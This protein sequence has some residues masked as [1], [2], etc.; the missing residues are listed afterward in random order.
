MALLAFL[1]AQAGLKTFAW[2]DVATKPHLSFGEKVSFK[3]APLLYHVEQRSYPL[4]RE[5]TLTPRTGGPGFKM[6]QLPYRR[7]E[8][9]VW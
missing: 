2:E 8:R 9:W 7:W 5:V 3:V 1:I 6:I 4:W